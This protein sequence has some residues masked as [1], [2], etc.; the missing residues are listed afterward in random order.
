[1]TTLLNKLMEA[2]T[3]KEVDSIVTHNLLSVDEDNMSFFCH[4]ANNAK[5]RI[6]RIQR[7]AK[8]SYK[9]FEKN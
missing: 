6:N 1:M 9:T 3:Q 2:R 4:C 5:K 8:K 7:E